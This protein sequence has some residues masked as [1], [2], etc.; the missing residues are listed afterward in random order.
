MFFILFL[1]VRYI[2]RRRLFLCAWFVCFVCLTILLLN[3]V[4]QIY[5]I[6]T[7]LSS[8]SST[9]LV[10]SWKNPDPFEPGPNPKPTNQNNSKNSSIANDTSRTM[11]SSITNFRAHSPATYT[12]GLFLNIQSRMIIF[13][14]PVANR[15]MRVMIDNMV[16]IRVMVIL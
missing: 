2:E 15:A 13:T 7:A 16:R 14:R 4:V 6:K 9:F 11:L 8:F 3:K 1:S 12:H 5:N 10:R